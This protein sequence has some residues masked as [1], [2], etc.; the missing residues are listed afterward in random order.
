MPRTASI[1][2]TSYDELFRHYYPYVTGLVHKYRVPDDQIEDVSMTLLS[3]FIEHNMLD[4]YDPEHMGGNGRPVQFS[5]FLSGFIVAYVRHYVD[6]A[7]KQAHREPQWIDQDADSLVRGGQDG[8]DGAVN[9]LD[10]NGFT[11]QDDLSDIEYD[12]L[13]HT[14]RLHLARIPVKRKKNFLLLFDLILDQLEEHGR[15][16]I[17]ELAALF[18]V[19]EPLVQRWM[20]ELRLHVKKAQA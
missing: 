13:V 16:Y 14:I 12:L 11:H 4:Q 5:S 1:V 15:I 7:A 6:K 19:S 9:W 18:E 8:L 20:K 10:R 2:P 17:V 3:K